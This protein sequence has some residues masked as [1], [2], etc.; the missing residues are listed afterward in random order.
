MGFKVG[1]TVVVEP[2]LKDRD[3]AGWVGS[4]T[5]VLQTGMQYVAVKFPDFY[6]D[7]KEFRLYQEAQLS[8]FRPARGNTVIEDRRERQRAIRI[9]LDTVEPWDRITMTYTRPGSVRRFEL[10]DFPVLQKPFEVR[11]KSYHFT[12]SGMNIQ[13]DLSKMETLIVRKAPPLKDGTR[14]WIGGLDSID[15]TVSEGIYTC[16]GNFYCPDDERYAIVQRGLILNWS[17]VNT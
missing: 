12:F 10:K 15:R 5:E 7:G 4:V 11:P 2:T 9:L 3:D 17:P 13:L 16:H 8:L 1:Q 14:I 6:G